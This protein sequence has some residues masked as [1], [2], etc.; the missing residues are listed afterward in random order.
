MRLSHF[1]IDRPIFATVVSLLITIV[2][3]IAFFSLPVAQYPEIAPPTI[4]VSASYPG[5]SAQ[6]VSDTVAAPL[7]EKINGVENML[8]INSQATGDGNLRMTVTFALGTNLDTAQVL[9][10]NRVAIATAR[11][12]DDVKRIGVTVAKNSPDML[13]VV[14]LSSPDGSRDQL[15]MSNFA[16][17]QMMDVLARLDGVGDV[18]V[19]GARD[20]AMRVWIDPDKA[21]ARNLT[22]G[23]V[24]K[25]LQAQNV[26][27]AAGVLNQPPIPSQG[28]FQLSVQTQGRLTEPAQFENVIVKTDP[29]GRIVRLK[30]IARIELGAQDYSVS[31]SLNGDNAVPVALFQR[32]GSNALATAE[33]IIAKVEE[34]SKTFPTGITY[35]IAYNPTQFIAQSVK[36]VIKTIF[37]A[38]ILV[39]V[40]VIVFL[41]TWRASLI[42]VAA[43]PV[44][45]IGTFA[46]L[47]AMGY[48]LNNL[49]LFGLVLAVGIVVDDAIVVVENVE[50]NMR[51]GMNSR[52]AAHQTM[53]EVGGA[54]ISIALV[55]CAVFIP[56]AFIPGISGQFFRQ[57]AVTI[58]AS[59]VISLIVS[60][61]LS[62]ALCA[63]LFRGH[64][65]N[66]HHE[67]KAWT[68]P[69]TL[70]FRGFN[71]GFERMAGGY[72]RLTRVVVRRSFIMLAAYAG[73]IGLAGY[74]FVKT[75]KG[76][77]PGMDQGYLITV[78]QLPPGSSLERTR[79]VVGRAARIMAATP[80]VGH[81]VAFAG[82]DG[83]TFTNA[84]NA[85]AI[86]TPL[87]PFEERYAQGL[88]ADAITAELRKRLGAIQD[89]FI[90]TIAPPPVRG[91]GTAGGFKMMLQDK[92]GRGPKALEDAAQDM[93]AA[94]AQVPG[95]SGIFTL[96]NTRTPNVQLDIDRVRAQMLGVPTERISE[97]LQV[98]LGSA[99]VNEFNFLGRTFRVT[100]QAD[101]PYRDEIGD[102]ST[103]KVR[104][105]KGQMVPLGAV[106]TFRSDTGPYRVPRYNLFP[107]AEIQG[108]AAPGYASGYALAQ[109]RQLA[110]E[111]LPDGFGFEWT[112][113]ALQELL[114]G[115]NGLWVFAA[116]VLFVF[117]LLAAQYESWSLPAAVVLIVP[118]C[119]LA[120]VSGL[121]V[122]GMPINILAQIG[123]IVLIGLAAKNA[124]LIVEFARQA[125]AEG[126]DRI[127]AAVHAGRT[128]LRPILM[129]SLAFVLGVLPLVIA[130][131]AG[132]EMRQS[133]GTTVFFGMLGVTLFGL[134]FTPI[135]YVV[136]R[137]MVAGYHVRAAAAHAAE[138][139]RG[140]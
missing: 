81:T 129:T 69:F 91:I 96:F 137:K 71:R 23:E 67:G 126:M 92:G 122:R 99:F 9:V 56:A 13:M 110:D 55:L 70:F 65:P 40:V 28:A 7:E 32:P 20:Y 29:S 47:S 86:F 85:A 62:P 48:S 90:I 111:R 102:I 132:A 79:E 114:A 58:A 50:R 93:A 105:D 112:E 36:E 131:G 74:E 5:A 30:D 127:E 66:D 63:L 33:R 46:V 61:T 100:A 107:A 54:L 116:S 83:A 18:R 31:G 1:F 16:T 14:H 80:G 88:S 12:P 115:D 45:L 108:A 94:A 118:M 125:E 119:L 120:A 26:Q 77:I 140:H 97:A 25:A 11:L 72:G 53:D 24:V 44:S 87:K 38:V 139:A 98:Y 52:S 82:L 136:I 78:V 128:R 106:T 57:F 22:A 6:V 109:M 60:L 8:Y 121:I 73:L 75:P 39:V 95:L 68:R 3:G 84:S 76:F 43:I 64:G 101:A 133:L 34:M 35:T 19:F 2:G 15:Y 104:N 51:D 17:L 135:F 138:Q 134:V 37:E 103:I 27:I 49:S 21:A 42:P 117:L 113:L 89:A 4:V 10:Q 130:T 123:F 41:Q 59:T 124:I